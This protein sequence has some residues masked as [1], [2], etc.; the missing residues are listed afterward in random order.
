M[1]QNRR[2]RPTRQ[3][4]KRVLQESLLRNYPNPDRKGCRG[5]DI[6]RAMAERE[7][8]DEH[9]FWDE[10]VSQCSP[11]YREFLNFRHEVLARESRNRRNARLALAAGLALA[12]GA[13]SIYLSRRQPQ[14]SQPSTANKVTPSQPN[15]PLTLPPQ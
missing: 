8:P 2:D 4:V 13:G 3:Q 9:P 11:C 12:I 15:Q 14:T 1:S 5:T 6:L 7:F 10:H